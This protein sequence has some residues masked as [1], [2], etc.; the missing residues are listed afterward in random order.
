MNLKSECEIRLEDPEV[1]VENKKKH[2]KEKVGN[3][4]LLVSSIKGQLTSPL[5]L[6]KTLVTSFSEEVHARIEDID[7]SI[8][9]SSPNALRFTRAQF[10]PGILTP[11]L[12]DNWDNI[13]STLP[14]MDILSLS[15][16]AHLHVK[17][18]RELN[19]QVENLNTEIKELQYRLK[20]P[21]KSV[22]AKIWG[23]CE[24]I[25]KLRKRNDTVWDQRPNKELEKEIREKM[26]TLKIENINVAFEK[27]CTTWQNENDDVPIIWREE[28]CNRLSQ[29]HQ[30][31]DQLHNLA[32]GTKGMPGLAPCLQEGHEEHHHG[33]VHREEL[34]SHP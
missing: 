27:K 21:C 17:K 9:S 4:L 5:S 10:G 24:H 34:L 19:D 11:Y 31:R 16:T 8:K 30:R 7:I 14:A 13:P 1:S 33:G 26:T 29:L 2:V 15:D 12:D 28:I 3:A 20:M 23:D 18:I 32:S 6:A 22:L 25:C